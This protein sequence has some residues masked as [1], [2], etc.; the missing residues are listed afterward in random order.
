MAAEEIAG[1]LRSPAES[2]RRVLVS[3][4]GLSLPLAIVLVNGLVSG[5]SGY[6]QKLRAVERLSAMASQLEGSPFPVPP[7]KEPSLAGEVLRS[8]VMSPLG[9]VVVSAVV[10]VMV[11]L[12]GGRAGVRE[13]LTVNG[14]AQVPL[15]I[16]GLLSIPAAAVAPSLAAVP[17]LIFGIWSLAIMVIGVR[18]ASGM[19]TLRAAAS[20]LI[21]LVVLVTLVTLLTLGVLLAGLGV[22]R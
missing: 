2:F 11:R 5:I 3:G 6:Y 19:S 4:E 14:Y 21:P 20:V 10:L 13:L 22:G 17:A 15:V 9:W 1:V 7:I 12:L 8:V 18:E 16:G